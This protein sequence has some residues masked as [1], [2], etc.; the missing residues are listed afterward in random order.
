MHK[1]ETDDAR[2]VNDLFLLGGYDLEEI[3]NQYKA[4]GDAYKDVKEKLTAHFNPKTNV[5]VNRFNF[6]ELQQ[7]EEESFDE[8]VGRLREA[9]DQCEFANKDDE[10]VSQVIKKC[11]SV[12]L[13]RKLL[14]RESTTLKQAIE[15]GRL[16]ESINANIKK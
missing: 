7:F 6:R 14:A 1:K 2:M 12:T 3:Y 9:A 13:K 10:V 4:G 15:L 11:Q 8:F 5:Q 16:E